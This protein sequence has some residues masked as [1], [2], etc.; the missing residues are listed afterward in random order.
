MPHSDKLSPYTRDKHNTPF[1]LILLFLGTG[2]IEHLGVFAP[3]GPLKAPVLVVLSLA[4][5]AV[6][7]ICAIALIE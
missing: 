5:A 6:A 4:I 3:V 1:L 7:V 2:G